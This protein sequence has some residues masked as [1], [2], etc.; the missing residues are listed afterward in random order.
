MKVQSLATCITKFSHISDKFNYRI[1][2][3]VVRL[4]YPIPTLKLMFLYD[5]SK[6]PILNQRQNC[7]YTFFCREFY[8][9]LLYN[10]NVLTFSANKTIDIAGAIPK[11]LTSSRG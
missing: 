1:L 4:H 11:T 2:I 9:F 3:A 8:F 5:S 7:I 6:L 10:K